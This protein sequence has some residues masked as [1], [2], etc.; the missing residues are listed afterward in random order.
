MPGNLNAADAGTKPA[1]GGRCFSP[2]PPSVSRLPIRAHPRHPRSTPL[3]RVL[4]FLSVLLFKIIR[5]DSHPFAGRK[6]SSASSAP[7]C[8][9]HPIRRI[10]VHPW[11]K[12]VNNF[13][14]KFEGNLR[15]PRRTARNLE[16][17]KGN[18]FPVISDPQKSGCIYPPC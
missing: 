11:L 4:R 5:V 14:D 2:S 8:F 13:F 12:P 6:L 9:K 7:S 17:R 3:L 16:E 10:C 18:P 15:E 1:L